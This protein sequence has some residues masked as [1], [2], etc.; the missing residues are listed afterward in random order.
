MSANNPLTDQDLRRQNYEL[1]TEAN[2]L[3]L[4]YGLLDIIQKIGPAIVGGSL[5]LNLMGRRDIDIYVQLS[6]GQEISHFF[7]LG[8]TIAT[9]FEVLKA[10]YSNHFIRHFPGFDH[11]LFWGIQLNHNNRRWKLD[12]WGYGPQHFENHCLQFRKLQESLAAVEP[13]TILRLKDAF[14]EDETYRDGIT[15]FEIY[16]AV[17]EGNVKTAKEFNKWRTA[18]N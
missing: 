10:S 16:T 6:N 9:K 12:L 13:L 1:C 2:V 14:R 11:G 7:A 17:I 5:A 4:E 8:G 15:G 18:N 3:L